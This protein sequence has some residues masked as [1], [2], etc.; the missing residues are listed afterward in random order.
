MT[1]VK[2]VRE[3][4]DVRAKSNGFFYSNTLKQVKL[5]AQLVKLGE[6]CEILHESNNVSTCLF[7]D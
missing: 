2:Y 1:D 4:I 6:I 7:D 3:T 5:L